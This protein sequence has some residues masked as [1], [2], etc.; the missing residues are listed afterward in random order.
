[1]FSYQF[2]SS[3]L[4]ASPELKP[5]LGN[6]LTDSGVLLP[7]PL[8]ANEQIKRDVEMVQQAILQPGARP[9]SA[10][11]LKKIYTLLL[12][13]L[14]KIN[15]SG[16]EEDWNSPIASAIC[17]GARVLIQV[18]AEIDLLLKAWLFED[19]SSEQYARSAATH[20][21][22]FDISNEEA[23]QIIEQKVAVHWAAL[24]AARMY[25]A[26]ATAMLPY[27]GESLANMVN[28]AGC[29]FGINLALGG[30]GNTHHYSN[31]MI[32]NNGEHGHLYLFHMPSSENKPGGW[33]VGIEQS[34]PARSDQYGGSHSMM[35]AHHSLT[36]T[37]GT[38]FARSFHLKDI[39]PSRYYNGLFLNLTLDDFEQAKKQVV[40]FKVDWLHMTHFP[41]PKSIIQTSPLLLS[42][43]KIEKPVQN[44]GDKGDTSTLDNPSSIMAQSLQNDSSSME[45]I[46]IKIEELT[47]NLINEEVSNASSSLDTLQQQSSVSIQSGQTHSISVPLGQDK[48]STSLAESSSEALKGSSNE[49]ESEFKQ[50]PK[51]DQAETS[52]STS[53]HSSSKAGEKK[54]EQILKDQLLNNPIK[55]D[56]P[57]DTLTTPPSKVPTWKYALAVTLL[58]VGI[59]ALATGIG[60]LVGGILISL[61]CILMASGGGFL[62]IAS[63]S[64]LAYL[65]KQPD[66]M[67][68]SSGP[69][70]KKMSA[71]APNPSFGSNYN[72]PT[73]SPEKDESC[74]TH[75]QSRLSV[76]N[77]P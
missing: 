65:G 32:E 19:E 28:P 58:V 52:L 35:A 30:S 25:T 23:I 74:E 5:E 71:S 38:D 64:Y 37:G 12:M 4:P 41:K 33:L 15:Q 51:A 47:E 31:N 67:G 17:H 53:P 76:G 8:D 13:G 45:S 18:P 60:A 57:S 1:M 27:V 49:S 72:Q 26:W 43:I 36:A 16:Q 11:I 7:N 22:G 75:S 77:Q 3:S 46:Q 54:L 68:H 62:T 10:T 50:Q 48:L 55:K 69:V 63:G 44:D 61:S 39:G 56:A 21:I 14:K 29:H 2:P 66:V 42:E 59:A 9:F 6:P 70:I 24:H 40:E 73:F 34:A 20:G